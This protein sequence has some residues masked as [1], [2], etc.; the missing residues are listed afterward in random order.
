MA[1]TT[2]KARRQLSDLFKEG[3]EVRFGRDPKTN[4]PYGKVGP[5]IDSMG[6]RAA[7]PEN[8]V[9]VFVRPPDPLQRDMAMREANA[10]RA[11]ALVKAKRDE[12]SEEHLTILAFLA[13]MG[14]ETLVDYVVLGDVA[15]RRAEAEREV[16]S[17]EEWKEMDAYQDAMRQF[18]GMSDEARE[19]RCSGPRSTARTT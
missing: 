1:T 13:D 3:T 7:C 14:D 5:F 16:L 9:A 12:E 4:K 2:I 15:K 6:N 8:E 19:G 11:R 17:L 18:E 10:K